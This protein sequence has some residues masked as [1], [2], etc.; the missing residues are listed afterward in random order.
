MVHIKGGSGIAASAPASSEAFAQ[1]WWIPLK[2]LCHIFLFLQ[3][4]IKN[5]YWP[6]RGDIALQL[7]KACK[8]FKDH[9]VQGFIGMQS[10]S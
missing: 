3:K 6:H 7:I 9:P 10:A 2:F 8:D 1:H 5:I 4:A